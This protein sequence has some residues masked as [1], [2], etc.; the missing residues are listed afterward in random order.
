MS[1]VYVYFLNTVELS[2]EY[3]CETYLPNASNHV[4]EK[5]ARLKSDNAIR[6]TLSAYLLL[7]KACE[8][9]GL[10]ECDSDIA[11]D[12]YGKPYFAKRTDKYFNIS[13]SHERVMCAIG[14]VPVGCDVQKIE[15]KSERALKI[16]KRF[17]TKEE[18]EK[19]M[20]VEEKE[21][22]NAFFFRMW[23]LKESYIKCVGGGL[24][25]P[26]D[27]FSVLE[28]RTPDGFSLH[29][30]VHSDGYRYSCTAKKCASEISFVSKWLKTE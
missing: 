8:E 16:A 6:E 4:K 22:R 13:H 25:I 26:L 20:S 18:F 9:L 23:T 15:D 21:E 1:E 14:D 11:T 17:F 27:S 30:F 10:N 28:G 7:H 5:V 2:K 29:S 24:A 19:L 3:L 12:A